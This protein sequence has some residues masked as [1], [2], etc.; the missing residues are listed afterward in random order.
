[1]E[2]PGQAEDYEMK[3]LGEFFE[4]EARL[5]EDDLMHRIQLMAQLRQN[6]RI[7]D[8]YRVKIGGPSRLRAVLQPSLFGVESFGQNVSSLVMESWAKDIAFRT[9]SVS[10]EWVDARDLI[11]EREVNGFT[12][13]GQMVPAEAFLEDLDQDGTAGNAS[14]RWAVTIADDNKLQLVLQMLPESAEVVNG[15]PALRR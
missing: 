15:K 5:L 14:L 1:M 11:K 9:N 2:F 4:A 12:G 6:G 13:S 8:D 7:Q 10:T 3:L